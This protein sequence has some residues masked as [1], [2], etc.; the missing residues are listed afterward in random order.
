MTLTILYG[1]I[2]VRGGEY[3]NSLSAFVLDKR[4]DL[5]LT[6]KEYAKKIGVSYVTLSTIEN[7]KIIGSAT[8]RKLSSYYNISTRVLREMMLLEKEVNNE[9]Y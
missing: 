1:N 4:K 3:V 8:L 6:Q 9:N 5:A 7:G 2:I